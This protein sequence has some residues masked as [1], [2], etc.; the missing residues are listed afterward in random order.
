VLLRGLRKRFQGNHRLAKHLIARAR[1]ERAAER[2]NVAAVLYEEVIALKPDDARV[3]IQCGHMYKEAG[4]LDLA[5]QYYAAA[6][7]QLPDDA[8]LALQLGHFYKLSGRPADAEREYGRAASLK[9][10]WPAP[11]AELANLQAAG[12]S[13]KVEPGEP[14]RLSASSTSRPIPT[15][16]SGEIFLDALR[17][18]ELVPELA[19]RAP[20]QLLLHHEESID[21]RRLGRRETSFW[22]LART[23]RG[24]EAV[25]GFVVS[26]TPILEMQMMINGLAVY[27][28]PLSGGFKL[29]FE[30]DRPQLR[31]YVYNLWYDFGALAYGRYSLELRFIDANRHSRS[32]HDRVVVAEPLAAADFPDSDAL[33]EITGSD[34]A[35][36]E[37]AIRAAP[38]VVR[39]AARALFPDGVKNVLVLRTDQLGDMV[40]SIPAITRLRELVP[41]A[42]IVGLLTGANAELAHTLGL[43]DEII[44]ID[45]PD[46]K[47]ERRRLMSLEAQENLRHRLRPY[48]F[49]LAI[50]LAQS[51]VSRQLLRLA[52]AKFT[53]GHG[54]DDTP[55]LSAEVIFTTRDRLSSMDAAPHSAKVLAMVEAL[56]AVLKTSAPVIRRADIGPE[57]LQPFGLLHGEPYALLHAGA[58]IEF[59]RWTKYPEL[60]ARILATTSLKVVLISEDAGFRETIPEDVL[61]NE[62]FQF[63]DKR[64]SFDAFDALVSYATVMVGNDSGPKHLASLR[65]VNVVTIFTARIPWVEWGQENVGDIISRKV[66]CQGCAIF[67]DPEECGKEFSCIADITLDEV[68]QVVIKYVP[69]LSI[70]SEQRA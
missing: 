14:Q 52:G 61:A 12:F 60:A 9:P 69:A 46:D 70:V 21:V 35:V 68:F 50:D 33:V 65:G 57:S 19:P 37:K 4:N 62:R 36:L 49:D 64:L 24:V 58:R 11:R 6:R 1:K 34:P 51:N 18:A 5:G 8:D 41:D 53:Y 38:S 31:K 42:R 45:F 55:W 63:L 29:R 27:R 7:I 22:G 67:H 48:A 30:R 39:P 54:G 13:R 3:K 40:A 25:R 66:P 47:L 26:E 59:S 17:Q 16:P 10:N 20:E 56:G 28:G 15:H 43:F 23:L 2:F 44:V 32:F